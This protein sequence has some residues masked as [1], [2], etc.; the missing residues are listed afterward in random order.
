MGNYH[1][2]CGAGEKLEVVTPEVYLSLFGSIPDFSKKLATCRKY[3]ISA[4]IILQS[5]NQLKVKYKDDW[6][7]IIGNCDS[8]LFLGAQEQD[9]LE[10]VSKMLGKETQKT[11]G[12]SSSKGGKGSTSTSYNWKGRDLMTVDELRRMDNNDCIYILRGEYPYKGK[13]HQFTNHPNYV[14]TADATHKN[15]VFI[16]N[17][18]EKKFESWE[19]R[20]NHELAEKYPEETSKIVSYSGTETK[21]L[22]FDSSLVQIGTHFGN[23][24]KNIIENNKLQAQEKEQFNKD[25]NEAMKISITNA[26]TKLTGFLNMGDQYA[27]SSESNFSGNVNYSNNTSSVNS[28]TNSQSSSYAKL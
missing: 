20:Y 25:L 9:T 4:T 17:T 6:G 24:K 5:I 8:F 21:S 28:N 16:R 12:R 18:P 1:A 22:K 7:T 23:A 15:Y 14:F 19:L 13:K 26:T 11:Q 27:E 10:Y 3:S 2:R